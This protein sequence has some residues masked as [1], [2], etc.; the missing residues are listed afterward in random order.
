[1][2][3]PI[4]ELSE[5]SNSSEIDLFIPL[6]FGTQDKLK[7]Y[8]L[9]KYIELNNELISF[10]KEIILGSE[11]SRTITISSGIVKFDKS[12]L[13]RPDAFWIYRDLKKLEESILSEVLSKKG[14]THISCRLFSVSGSEMMDPLK[15]AL[16]DMI[17]QAVEKKSITIHASNPIFRKYVDAESLCRLLVILSE[18]GQNRR[19]DSTG[20]LIEVGDLARVIA[21]TFGLMSENVICPEIN[22]S[23][24]DNYYSTDESMENFFLDYRIKLSSIENQILDTYLGLVASDYVK[25]K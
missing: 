18:G 19:F 3:L 23:N 11:I 21:N 1:M 22:G 13:D 24:S 6:A 15:Y 25:Q 12:E 20:V 7:S 10:H 4:K 17:V 16:G 14:V 9:K 2:E 5:L 8:G